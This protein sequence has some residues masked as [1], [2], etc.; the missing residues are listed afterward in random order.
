MERTIEESA[1]LRRI[2]TDSIVVKKRDGLLMVIMKAIRMVFCVVLFWRCG[3][4]LPR[5]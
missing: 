1:A 4:H 3:V 5:R 2:E